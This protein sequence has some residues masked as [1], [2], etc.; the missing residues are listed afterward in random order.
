[1]SKRVHITD[2]GGVLYPFEKG[3]SGNPKGR[4]RKYIS[5]LKEHGYKLSEVNDTIQVMMSLTV[6]ELKAVWDDPNRTVMEKTIAGA[7][8][9]GLANGSLYA[10]DTLM[11]RVYG[12]PIEKLDVEQMTTIT[13]LNVNVV[14]TELKIAQSEKDVDV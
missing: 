6:D 8:R 13:S 14:K 11:N 1:M 4:P 2:K 10:M 9:K 5:T 12:K 7:I 3:K